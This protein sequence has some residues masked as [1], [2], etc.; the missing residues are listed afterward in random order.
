M[1]YGKTKFTALIAG[2]CLLCCAAPITALFIS[3]TALAGFGFFSESREMMIVTGTIV[4]AFS[5]YLFW[6][7]SRKN[8]S[9]DVPKP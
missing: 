3:G 8:P 5:V 7:R 1:A 6:R 2:L 4:A 9:C